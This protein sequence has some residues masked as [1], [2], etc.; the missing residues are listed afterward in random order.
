M[1]SQHPRS[2]YLHLRQDSRKAQFHPCFIPII[3]SL[4]TVIA[5]CILVGRGLQPLFPHRPSWATPFITEF[6]QQGA[7]VST[8]SKQRSTRSATLLLVLFLVGLALHLVT[9]FYPHLN[10]TAAAPAISWVNNFLEYKNTFDTKI[11]SCSSFSLQLIV[12]KP[13]LLEY[14]RL[15]LAL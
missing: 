14:L 3:S 13:L 1:N 2:I 9:V 6:G 7:M 12:Q 11:R 10:I 4:P 15:C 5:I 8:D